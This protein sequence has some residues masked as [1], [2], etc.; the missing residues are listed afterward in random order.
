MDDFTALINS[1]INQKK[2]TLSQLVGKA[3]TGKPPKYI[4][5][6]DLERQRDAEYWEEERRERARIEER[7]RL[8]SVGRLGTIESI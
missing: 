7:K 5:R 1:E 2:R 3:E 4:R 6:A 8:V